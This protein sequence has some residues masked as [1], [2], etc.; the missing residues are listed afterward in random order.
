MDTENQQNQNF[1]LMANAALHRVMEAAKA[2]ISQMDDLIQSDLATIDQI[3]SG[4]CRLTFSAMEKLLLVHGVVLQDHQPTVVKEIFK[5]L[6]ESLKVFEDQ[7]T[8]QSVL[9]GNPN[10]NLMQS[11]KMKQLEAK[12]AAE[13]KEKEL[14]IA[15]KDAENQRLQK[16]IEE[17]ME[18]EKEKELQFELR[19]DAQR[20]QEVKLYAL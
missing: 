18:K 12:F 5:K 11:I 16:Q 19:N 6:Q 8:F 7:K 3:Q 20:K 10:T 4:T 17:L 2:D 13:K 14:I 15:E 1:S 9:L